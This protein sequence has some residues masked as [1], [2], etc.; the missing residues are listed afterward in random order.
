MTRIAYAASALLVCALLAACCGSAL[1]GEGTGMPDTAA[2]GAAR[3]LV[4][5][6]LRGATDNDA[7]GLGAWTRS[8]IDRA[9]E[10][11]G[12][13]AE[14]TAE[15]IVTDGSRDASAH[16]LPAE[17]KAAETASG[18][19]GRNSTAEIVVL[20]SLAVPVAS[21]RQWAQEAATAG[22]PLVLRGI[23]DDGLRAFADRMRDRLGGH[24]AGVAVDPR[25]FRL[26]GVT[27]VPAVVAVPG[28]AP[29]CTSRGCA[30]DP[31]PLH[32]LIAGNIG[33]AAAL[34]AIADEGEAGR[35]AAAR[36]LERL[37]RA[38]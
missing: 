22:I 16:S 11:A 3:T 31:A 37:R 18:L 36:T 9:L 14:A 28:G 13:D 26:F 24:A 20:M 7:D 25:L 2:D 27:R 30:D 17:R 38:R 19:A 23:G 10:R 21:W 5:E 8:V 4:D 33:L 34:E 15:T 12:R 35:A 29:P 32:D 6:V 1:A